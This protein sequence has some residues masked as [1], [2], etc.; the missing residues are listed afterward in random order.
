M[1]RINLNSSL[2]LADKISQ[3]TKARLCSLSAEWFATVNALSENTKI[4]FSLIIIAL[5]ISTARRLQRTL[6]PNANFDR[7]PRSRGSSRFTICLMG[8]LIDVNLTTDRAEARKRLNE[9]YW[10]VSRT[11]PCSLKPGLKQWS[12]RV[13]SIPDEGDSSHSDGPALV[14]STSARQRTSHGLGAA[15]RNYPPG[16]PRDDISR[17]LSRKYLPDKIL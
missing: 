2:I 8:V 15:R 3:Q 6:L 11:S 1:N 4:F 12:A 13:W 10:Q 16:S 14:S 9:C 7:Q 5:P 17:G